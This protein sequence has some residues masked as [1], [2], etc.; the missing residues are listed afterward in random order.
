MLFKAHY[1]LQESGNYHVTLKLMTPKAFVSPEDLWR[2]LDP[3][4][5]PADRGRVLIG[6]E[7][8]QALYAAGLLDMEPLD[9]L[10]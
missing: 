4:A 3:T 5:S 6:V 1:H 8:A 9:D 10:D 7:Q 2:I